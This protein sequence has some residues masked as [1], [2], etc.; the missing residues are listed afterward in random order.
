ME[1]K[2]ICFYVLI[3]F[4]SGNI[5]GQQ[6]NSI[7]IEANAANAN[8]DSNSIG[9]CTG[10]NTDI[11]SE[12]NGDGTYKLKATA[13]TTDTG[14]LIFNFPASSTEP[15]IIKFAGIESTGADVRLVTGRNSNGSYLSIG[16]SG[17]T[18]FNDTLREY[19]VLIDGLDGTDFTIEFFLYSPQIG[20]YLEIDNIS[21]IP[22]NQQNLEF[23]NDIFIEANAA[24]LNNDSNTIGSCTGANTDIT[25][26][27]NGDGTF[28]IRA[29]VN[30]LD[31]GRLI[32]NMPASSTDPHILKFTGIES[33]GADVRLVRA[34][35]S[36]DSYLS[37]GGGY[38]N[39]SD[40]LEDYTVLLERFNGTDF[41]VEF[42]LYN[43]E[44]GDYLE[45]DNISIVPITSFTP[46]GIPTAPTLS[47][48]GQ[49]DTT[50]D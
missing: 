11:T 1:L 2:K 20:H 45:I 29:T 7:F 6:T 44:I 40:Q 38:I 16:G 50:V 37:F 43:T 13:N 27:S 17:Y 14:R 49:T 21:V 39:F 47:S 25:S 35:N 46:S 34:R 31:T 22:I 36:D 9:S 30:T 28:K 23:G 33:T 19:N 42:F 18:N 3:V 12:S 4:I 24:N 15:H 48:S 41:T 10:V 5:F 32:F 8:N 26:E